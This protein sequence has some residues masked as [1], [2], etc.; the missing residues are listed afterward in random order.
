MILLMKMKTIIEELS[1]LKIPRFTQD[2]FKNIFED[3]PKILISRFPQIPSPS[4]SAF[5]SA[6]IFQDFVQDFKIFFS[7]TAEDLSGFKIRRISC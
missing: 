5:V 2:L 3:F 7:L 6:K 1:Q 4:A